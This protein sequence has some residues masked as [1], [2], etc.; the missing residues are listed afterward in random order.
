MFRTVTLHPIIDQYSLGLVRTVTVKNFFFCICSEERLWRTV[1]AMKMTCH[2]HL[3]DVEGNGVQATAARL[4]ASLLGLRRA[5]DR[6]IGQRTIELALELD[7]LCR[8]AGHVRGARIDCRQGRLWLTQAGVAADVIL[9]PGQSFMADGD[10]AIVVQSVPAVASVGPVAP[11]AHTVSAHA[12]AR[13]ELHRGPKT[14]AAARIGLDLADGQWTG[15]WEQ[16]VFVVVWLCGVFGV[17]YCLKTALTLSW[18][19]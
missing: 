10:G 15:W 1:G 17:G 18:R 16:L 8:I 4:G 3:L 19:P 12:G 11:G 5:P 9:Q 13:L 7:S 6:P 2:F 14:G